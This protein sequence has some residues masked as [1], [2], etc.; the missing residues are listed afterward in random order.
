MVRSRVETPDSR[1]E[2]GDRS[3]LRLVGPERAARAEVD[4]LLRAAATLETE[5]GIDD[6]LKTLVEQAAGLLNVERARF[7]VGNAERYGSDMLWH[8]GVW[9]EDLY[10]GRADTAGGHV[11]RTGRPYRSNNPT[12]DPRTDQARLASNNVRSLLIVPLMGDRKERLGLLSVANSRNPDGFSQHDVVLLTAFCRFASVIIAR[13]SNK[14]ARSAAEDK[15]A[16]R[17][18]E[19][20][21]LL[22]A[23]ATLET[24]AG[25][26]ELLKTLVEQAAG[27][28][29]VELARFVVGNPERYSSTLLWRNGTWVEDLFEGTPSGPGSHVWRSGRPYR[30]NNPAAEL[31]ADRARHLARNVRSLLVVPLVGDGAVALGL[32]IVANC[33]HPDGFSEHDEQLLTAFCSFASIVLLRARNRAARSNA[34]Q[35]AAQRRREVEALLDAADQLNSAIAPKD[36]L[37]RIAGVAAELFA[38]TRVNVVTNEGEFGLLRHTWADGTWMEEG[39]HLPFDRSIGGW[40]IQHAVP[41]RSDDLEHDPLYFHPGGG[42]PRHKTVMSVPI[43]GRN[44]GVAGALTLFERKDGEPFTDDDLRLAEGIAHHAATAFERATL[45]DELQSTTRALALLEERERIAMDLHDG[46]IQSLYGVTLGMEAHLRAPRNTRT[47]GRRTAAMRVA[48]GQI[49]GVIQELRSYITDLRWEQPA[50]MVLAAALSALV[51]ELRANTQ[52]QTKLVLSG[53]AGS[54]LNQEAAA[55]LIQIAREATSNV[56]RHAH[57]SV[58]TVRLARR[59]DRLLM[60]VRDDGCGFDANEQATCTGDGL[61]NMA[62]RA[63][64]L[65]AELTI[66]SEPGHGT[67]LRLQVP[68]N[69]TVTAE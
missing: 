3:H 27:L 24:E 48:I 9:V 29:D 46:A 42:P 60:T 57:A 52:V 53:G 25:I 47:R 21:A 19:V 15:A 11:W 55:N 58:T 18:H 7:V 43:A 13:A 31:G 41:Y 67:E 6:L 22:R 5:A 39:T 68:L 2:R 44:G 40:V 8:N 69:A 4:A 59:G 65:G 16:R 36:V 50:G 45:T 23:A 17:G 37:L 14:A 33:R 64:I 56:A 54:M 1:R 34:E 38:V 12:Q 10:V 63:R 32:L 30:S 26:D 62:E 28:L 35:E 49:G 61:R 20:D 66:V 51:E